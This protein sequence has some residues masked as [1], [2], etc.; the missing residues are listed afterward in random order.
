M[1]G[2]CAFLVPLCRGCCQ[3]YG[4]NISTDFDLIRSFCN[5]FFFVCDSPCPP[6]SLL[7][8]DVSGSTLFTSRLQRRRRSAPEL[9]E[10][11][12]KGTR[13]GVGACSGERLGGWTLLESEFFHPEF[14]RS[15]PWVTFIGSPLGPKCTLYGCQKPL[16]MRR[17]DA[18]RFLHLTTIVLENPG[19]QWLDD[20]YHVLPQKPSCNY[21][22]QSCQHPRYFASQPESL[23]LVY[24]VTRRVWVHGPL[25][26]KD[27]GLGFSNKVRFWV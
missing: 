4:W 23:D 9:Y 12:D 26:E 5:M 14:Q 19:F 11:A 15:R 3:L 2:R 27:Y 21:L 8:M 7:R 6:S 20:N 16:R 17:G 25:R 1:L 22:Y 13:A 10:T 18:E 24:K